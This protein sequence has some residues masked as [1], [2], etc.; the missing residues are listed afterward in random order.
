MGTSQTKLIMYFDIGII[1]SWRG[2]RIELITD[3]IFV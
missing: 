3:Y 1:L 2:E